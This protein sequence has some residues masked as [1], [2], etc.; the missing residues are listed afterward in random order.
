VHVIAGLQRVRVS[1]QS[2]LSN[3]LWPWR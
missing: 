3:M 2:R 1:G